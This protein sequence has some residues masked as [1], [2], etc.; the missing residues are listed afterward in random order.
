MWLLVACDAP[1]RHV[2]KLPG[3]EDDVLGGGQSKQYVWIAPGAFMMGCNPAVFAPCDTDELPYH[4]VSLSG[5]VIDRTEVTESAWQRCMDA[6]RCTLPKLPVGFDPIESPEEPVTGVTWAQAA[7]YCAWLGARL[8]TEAEWEHAARGGDGRVYPWGGEAPDCTRASYLDCGGLPANIGSFPM[9]HSPLGVKDM[10]G[11]AAE[12]VADWYD[13]DEYWRR[14][15]QVVSDPRGPATGVARV[16]RGGSF[17][18]IARTLRTSERAGWAPTE[19]L[20]YLGFRCARDMDTA[21]GV[22]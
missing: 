19:A 21:P 8:P 10:A 4:T 1:E 13:E 2:S 12:W 14:E 22:D 11:N 3:G 15:G 18:S 7:G 6:G 17:A 9:G 16:I 5:Y 20:P